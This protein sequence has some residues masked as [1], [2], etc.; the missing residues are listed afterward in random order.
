[1]YVSMSRLRVEAAES[2][3]LVAA[4]RRRAPLVDRVEGFVD[5]EVWRS[6]RDPEE[7]LMVS[8]W[9]DRAAFTPTC[10]APSTES[11]TT[12]SSLR[13][14][15][16]STSS[17]SSTCTPTTWSPNEPPAGPPERD[18]RAH[19][20]RAQRPEDRA[21]AARRGRRRPL[22]RRIPRRPRA[23]R[24]SRPRVGDPRHL[25]LP[26]MGDP[27]RRWPRQPRPRT[28]V[29]DHSPARARLPARAP[30]AKPRAH[31]PRP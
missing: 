12:A 25:A 3:A 10:A 26:S 4:F 23:L 22:L 16:R 18:A 17:D 2:D 21:T 29:A 28:R 20:R 8:R 11:P 7:V 19:E 5:L 15:P 14:K 31:R 9:R 24:P 30:R 6:D 13:S 27:G 1:M